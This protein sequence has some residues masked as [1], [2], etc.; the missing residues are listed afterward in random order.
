MAET[1]RKTKIEHYA[2]RLE[3][4]KAIL[5]EQ[6]ASEEFEDMKQFLKGQLSA[7]D[8]I[9]KE[10]IAEFE[11]ECEKGETSHGKH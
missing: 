8:M 7:V 1:Y 6:L 2:A 3:H 4:R 9:H 10:I 11:I 5:K